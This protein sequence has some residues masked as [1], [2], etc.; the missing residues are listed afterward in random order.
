MPKASKKEVKK[1]LE[2]S[3]QVEKSK[4]LYSIQK[5]QEEDSWFRQQ[6]RRLTSVLGKIPVGIRRKTGKKEGI[7]KKR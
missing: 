3:K 4:D 2:K 6:A 7:K 1:A 5:L